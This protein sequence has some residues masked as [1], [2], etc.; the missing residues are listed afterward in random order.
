MII[1]LIGIFED[2]LPADPNL[3]DDCRTPLRMPKGADVTVNIQIF[4]R[5]GSVHSLVTGSPSLTLVVRKKTSDV[6][7]TIK[8]V[9][10]VDPARGAQ[11]WASFT[12]VPNDTLNEFIK[13]G[14]FC[15]E[16]WLT[17]AGKVTAVM[18]LSP[19][20]LEPSALP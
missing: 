8:K 19:Y 12:F 11:G 5:S 15:F 10:V 20:H 18:P 6:T 14:I 3:P 4:N 2:G 7:A 16:I 17:Q 13:A 1:N 9:G